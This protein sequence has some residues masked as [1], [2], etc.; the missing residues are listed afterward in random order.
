MQSSEISSLIKRKSVDVGGRKL[1]Y[2]LKGFKGKTVASFGIILYEICVSL[3]TKH[4][5]SYYKTGGLFSN[6]E[7]AIDFFNFI[8]ENLVTPQNLPYVVEDCFY[9]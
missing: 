4:G 8:S 2:E 6:V 9:F 5:V 1:E 3:T 7:K